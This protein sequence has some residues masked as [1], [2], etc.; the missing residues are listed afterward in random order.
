MANG[1]KG[2]SW[3]GRPARLIPGSDYADMLE[4][5]RPDFTHAVHQLSGKSRK[6]AEREALRAIDRIRSGDV[7]AYRVDDPSIPASE[8]HSAKSYGEDVGKYSI[9]GQHRY[10]GWNDPNFGLMD[11]LFGADPD[12][13]FIAGGRDEKDVWKTMAHEAVHTTGIGHEEDYQSQGAFDKV[14]E[15]F[16]PRNEAVSDAT[17]LKVGLGNKLYSILRQKPE[18]AGGRR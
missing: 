3:Y 7:V 12:T 10:A 4:D 2:V 18:I 6:K 9:L 15:P 13:I 14:L 17:S 5:R 11:R 16:S 8:T 1:N